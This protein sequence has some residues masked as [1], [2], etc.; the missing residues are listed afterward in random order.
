MSKRQQVVKWS[1][2]KLEKEGS[3]TENGAKLSRGAN[4][5]L[6]CK[7]HQRMRVIFK[8]KYGRLIENS[9]AK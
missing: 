3:P 4:F 1:L 8:A 9:Y 6:G 7:G 2:I 5:D